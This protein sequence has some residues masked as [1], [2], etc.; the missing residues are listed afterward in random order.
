[1]VTF[2]NVSDRASWLDGRGGGITGGAA[3]GANTP[4]VVRKAYPLLFDENRQRKKAYQ[5]VVNF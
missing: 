3:A 2:W 4:R 1:N 5:A